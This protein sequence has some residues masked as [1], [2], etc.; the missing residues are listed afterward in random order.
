LLNFS[1]ISRSVALPQTTLKR[2]FSLLQATFLVQLLRPWARNL[3]KRI[4]QTPKVYLNDTGLLAYLLG[5][6]LD[7]LK[8]EGNQAGA[9]LENFVLM[10][11][12][13]QSTWSA[14][15]PEIFFWRTASGQE[16]DLVLEDR[17]G[18]V[19]GIEVKASATLRGS[20]V[21]GLQALA[22]AAG[23]LWLRGVVL[24]TGTEV[25]PFAANLHGVPISRLWAQ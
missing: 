5:T 18:R 21:R 11:L 7:R 2:Y 15:Q 12:R 24:Y 17:T 16:V 8:S 25:I 9:V 1:D 10:E 13:K 19:V 23:K 3:G 20:D 4:I 14:T 22:D 6:T